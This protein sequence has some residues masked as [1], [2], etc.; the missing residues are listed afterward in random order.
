MR[1]TRG[2]CETPSPRTNRPPD[3]AWSVRDAAAVATLLE[4]IGVASLDELAAKALPAGILDRR[5]QGF[6]MPVGEWFRDD[7]DG[8]ARELWRD[9]GVAPAGY[10]NGDAVEAIFAEHRTGRR[11]HGRVLYALSIFCLWW[12]GRNAF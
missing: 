8:F 9:S 10:L 12:Q 4:T 1:S 5:K 7:L 6:K 2:A 11:D 3:V